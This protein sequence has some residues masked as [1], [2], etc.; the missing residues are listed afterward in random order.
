MLWFIGGLVRRAC[1]LCVRRV[2]RG[3]IVCGAG[4]GLWLGVWVWMCRRLCQRRRSS[5]VAGM[6]AGGGWA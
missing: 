5:V 3:R 1:C 4:R 2:S 6:A